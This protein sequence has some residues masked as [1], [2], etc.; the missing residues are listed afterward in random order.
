MKKILKKNQV[1]L[2][3]LTML[4]AVAGYLNYS[5]KADEMLGIAES[6]TAE[7]SLAADAG[8]DAAAAG[9]DLVEIDSLDDPQEA[10]ADESGG[11]EEVSSPGEAILTNGVTVSDFLAQAKLTRE[12]T[13]GQNREALLEIVN[14]TELEEMTRQA[15]VD[16][17]VAQTSAA[18]LESTI[19][20]LLSSKGFEN[21]IVSVLDDSVDVVVC[22]SSITDAE[23]AQIEDI[24]KRKTE[25][26]AE[27]I[28]ITLMELKK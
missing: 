6:G 26:S 13:R 7:S 9:E 3:V 21:T 5:G 27:H 18:E 20:M 4:V 16:Q 24:V 1:I 25:L 2:T 22:R 8:K 15:A 12:Q 14:N 10:A 28:V 19:E 17:L 23:R 11:L